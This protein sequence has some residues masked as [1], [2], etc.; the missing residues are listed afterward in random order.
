MTWKGNTPTEESIT[1]RMPN[2]MNVYPLGELVCIRYLPPVRIRQ[3]GV[4][5]LPTLE[6]LALMARQVIE[7]KVTVCSDFRSILEC[8]RLWFRTALADMGA[9]DQ[10]RRVRSR[11]VLRGRESQPE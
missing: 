8:V 6:C 7:T 9:T 3:L 2:R 5:C 4:L 11:V 1:V 10:P